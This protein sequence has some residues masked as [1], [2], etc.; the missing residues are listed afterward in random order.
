M[1]F[2]REYDW[3]GEEKPAAM[4]FLASTLRIR[5]TDPDRR[6]LPGGR[7][8]VADDPETVFVCDGDG[9]VEIPLRDRSR[10]TFGLEWEAAGGDGTF[11]WNTI[12]DVE[13]RSLQDEDC[14]KRLSH[15]GFGGKDL[16]EQVREYQS[17]FG[18]R[19]SGLL[20]DIREQMAA[21]HD[22]GAMPGMAGAGSPA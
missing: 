17:H 22:G 21:W 3:E 16:T 18:L 6:P 19:E 14:G 10:K 7:C 15:L 20:A 13:V 9:I 12:L 4:A 11:P 1:G 5:L 2:V 8:R